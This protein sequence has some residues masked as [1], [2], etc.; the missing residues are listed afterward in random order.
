MN[1]RKVLQWCGLA[2][3]AL[4]LV[5]LPALADRHVMMNA[6]IA[7]KV[8]AAMDGGKI[9]LGKAIEAA[10][11][12]AKGKAVYAHAQFDG[13]GEFSVEVCCLVGDQLKEVMV[14]KTGKITTMRDE[15][16]YDQPGG[17]EKKEEPAKPEKPEKPEKP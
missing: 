3:C 5:A 17:K 2:F 1:G 9:S 13:K 11:T 12:H 7:K 10:E 4:G 8:V 14:D 6:D 16:N 15:P